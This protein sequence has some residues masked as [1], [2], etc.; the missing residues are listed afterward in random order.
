MQ[1]EAHKKVVVGVFLNRSAL[2]LLVAPVGCF[3]WALHARSLYDACWL[4]FA[5]AVYFW[6]VAG[7]LFVVAAGFQSPP[8]RQRLPKAAVLYKAHSH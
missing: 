3:L 7:I 1:T 6:P 2:F 8:T 4:C 5:G